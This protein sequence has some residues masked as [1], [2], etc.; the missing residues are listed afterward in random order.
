MR[1]QLNNLLS[2]YQN[3]PEYQGMTLIDVN[4][5]SMF[6]DRPIH[7][8]AVRGSI[9]ELTV[10]YENGADINAK[11]EYDYT[12]LLHAVEQGHIEAVKWLIG[13]GADVSSKN[14]TESD[15]LDLAKILNLNE[16]QAFL[17]KKP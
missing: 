5:V 16:I 12:P 1:I 4:Q 7:V 8:A 17:E 10:L 2:E 14:D 15:A 6:G 3:L 13:K 11:G 9:D